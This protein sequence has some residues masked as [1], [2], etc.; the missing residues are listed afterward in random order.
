MNKQFK[1][2]DGGEVSEEDEDEHGEETLKTSVND[3]FF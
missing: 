1:I 2:V 3:Y